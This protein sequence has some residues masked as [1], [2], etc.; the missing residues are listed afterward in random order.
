VRDVPV[1]DLI[2]IDE[3]GLHLGLIRLFAWAIEGLRAYGKQ[4][5]KGK[6]VSTVSALSITGVVAWAVILGAFD[7]LTFEAFIAARL[8]P[9][10]WPGAVVVM[11]NCSIHQEEVIRPLIEGAGARL[12]YSGFQ[13]YE[14]QQRGLSPLLTLRLNIPHLNENCCICHLIHLTFHPLKTFGQR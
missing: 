5:Q 2:F 3:S 1:E 9:K 6:N 12:V 14:V 13:M 7:G 10:L 11:D 4:P 8:V